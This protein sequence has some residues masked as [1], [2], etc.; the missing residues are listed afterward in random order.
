MLVGFARVSTKKQN[1]DRQLDMLMDYGDMV[2]ITDLSRVS[3]S[4]KDLL[5][6]VYR[7][8]DKG[9]SIKSLKD[10]WV[11]LQLQIHI[12]SFY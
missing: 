4:T 1:L 11:V 10:K 8:K 5:M 6:V 3:K 2:V 12:M 9:A 7:I